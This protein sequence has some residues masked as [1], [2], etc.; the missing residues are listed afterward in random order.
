MKKHEQIRQ[1]V[2]DEFGSLSS[3]SLIPP[4]AELVKRY[5]VSRVTIVRAL[6]E[7]V[8]E[9]MLER[10]QGRGTFIAEKRGRPVTKCIGVLSRR[11]PKAGHSNPYYGPLRAAMSQIFLDNNYTVTM[12]AAQCR[13]TGQVVD[14]VSIAEKPIDGLIVLGIM[15]PDYHARLHRAGLPVVGIEYHFEDHAPFDYVVQDCAQSAQEITRQ[16]IAEGHQRIAFLGHAAL[17]INP[18]YC[19]DQGSLERLTGIRWA[20]QEAGLMPPE[21]LF[22][23]APHRFDSTERVLEHLYSLDA[24]PTAIFCSESPFLQPV[25]DFVC[26]RD[27]RPAP[28]VVSIGNDKAGDDRIPLWRI[29]EPCGEMGRLAGQR[30]LARLEDPALP[31]EVIRIPWRLHRSDRPECEDMKRDVQVTPVK[32]AEEKARACAGG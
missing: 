7:L 4:E 27:I 26:R 30:M 10:Q 6:N 1:Q 20:C 21:E 18:M 29:I 11:I 3:G 17:N 2:I 22:F 14:P 23:Q 32:W 15:N 16:L 24:P 31:P 9:G 8:R 12:M 25:V 19:P 13:Q 5:G 28:T